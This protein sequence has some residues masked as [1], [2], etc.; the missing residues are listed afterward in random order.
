MQQIKT[1]KM[2]KIANICVCI[3]YNKMLN[4][5]FISLLCVQTFVLCTTVERTVQSAAFID[6]RCHP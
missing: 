5:V 3:F 1:T 4:T 2:E 6:L